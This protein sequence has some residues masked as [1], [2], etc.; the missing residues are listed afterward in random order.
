[1]NAKREILGIQ[2]YLFMA[3]I[4]H[5]HRDFYE[6]YEFESLTIAVVTQWSIPQ[7]FNV[8]IKVEEYTKVT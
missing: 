1:M 3:G 5:S 8:G 7:C 2:C 6:F 4:E